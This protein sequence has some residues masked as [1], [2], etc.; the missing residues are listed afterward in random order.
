MENKESIRELL[1]NHSFLADAIALEQFIARWK[2]GTLPKR[3][4]THAA[5]VGV[6]AYFAFDED[7][8][9]TFAILRDGIRHYN[10]CV[11]TANTEDSGYHETLTG[12]WAAEVG[13]LVRSRSFQSRLDAV[14]AAVTA[15]G[16]DKYRFRG[17]YSFD[18]VT[19][20]RARREWIEPDLKPIAEASKDTNGALRV[21]DDSL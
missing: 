20:R 4:W 14:R 7:H 19:N 1:Q 21:P 11:G 9:R 6:A 3:F 13:R 15:F 12:F 5:H 2:L 17:Y 16:E 18:V 10:T 8:E